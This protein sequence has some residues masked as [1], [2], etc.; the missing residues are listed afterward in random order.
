MVEINYGSI[1][2]IEFYKNIKNPINNPL[3]DKFPHKFNLITELPTWNDFYHLWW[4]GTGTDITQF[5]FKDFSQSFFAIFA[6]KGN[7]ARD[8]GLVNCNYVQ[9]PL[10]STYA[11]YPPGNIGDILVSNDNRKV[12]RFTQIDTNTTEWKLTNDIVD[13]FYISGLSGTNKEK[14]LMVVDKLNTYLYNDNVDHP[15]LKDFIYYYS[16]EYD[17]NN[18]LIPTVRAV[19]KKF[20]KNKR[21]LIKYNG[22]LGTAAAYNTTNFGYQGDIPVSFEIYGVNQNAPTGTIQITGMQY[23]Y[24]INSIN[25]TDLCNELNGIGQKIDGI[26]D[27]I[28]NLVIANPGNVIPSPNA[29]PVKIQAVSK[30]FKSDFEINI[31][32]TGGIIGTTYGRSIIKNPSWDQIRILKYNQTLPLCT[33]VN[34]TYD[35]SKMKGKKNPKWI[36]TKESDSDFDDIYYN[37]KYFSYMFT[38]RGS[39]SISLSLEDTNGNTQ[40]VIK[41]EIIKII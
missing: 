27:Y 41:K 32:Y 23:P 2:A 14:A 4:D 12:Y 30:S 1:D 33:V 37:N 13:S 39:Y 25:L 36:L 18:N 3:V 29:Y 22:A 16:E 9:G 38:E 17:S 31:K 40:T 20:E 6:S 24:A 8:L 10:T 15:V 28:Y 26:K 21:H 7:E 11:S 35:N 5:E 19:S 34:F